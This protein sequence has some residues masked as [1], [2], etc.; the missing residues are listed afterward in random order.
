MKKRAFAEYNHKQMPGL[1]QL[2]KLNSDLLNLGDEV[3]IRAARSEKAVTIPIPRNIEDKDDSEDFK[4]GLPVLS[5]EDQAQADAAAAELEKS[6]NDFS[7]FL[8]DDKDEDSVK[9][10]KPKVDQTPDMSDIIGPAAGMDFDDFDLSE[11]EEAPPPKEP[12]KPKEIP[13]EDLDL[14]ALLAPSSKAKEEEVLQAAPVE[15]KVTEEVPFDAFENKAENKKDEKEEEAD[16]LL[17]SILGPQDNFIPEEK[18][19][20]DEF[21]ELANLNLEESPQSESSAQDDFVLPDLENF[22]FDENLLKN[23][24]LPSL[25]E[26]PVLEESPLLSESPLEEKENTPLTEEDKSDDPFSDFDADFTGAENLSDSINMNEGLPGEYDE[27]PGTEAE[28]AS[29]LSRPLKEESEEKEEESENLPNEDFSTPADFEKDLSSE[30]FSLPDFENEKLTEPSLPDFD[31]SG[32]DDMD[33]SQIPSGF[34]E[35]ALSSLPSESELNS[36]NESFS[37][38]SEKADENN[39]SSFT[40]NKLS[41]DSTTPPDIGD[42]FSS[43]SGD[44]FTVTNYE[45]GFDGRALPPSETDAVPEEDSGPAEIFDTSAMDGLDFSNEENTGLPSDFEL[46]NITTTESDDDI[47]NIPGFSDTVTADLNKKPKEV[48]H[49]PVVEDDSGKPKNSFTDAEYERFQKNLTF[50]PLNVRIALEDLVVKNEFTDD[51]VFEILEKVLR[52]VPARTLASELE[53]MMDI[54]LDV[55]RDFEHRTAEEYEAYKKSLEYQLKNRIIP[56]AIISTAAAIFIF[57]I[58]LLSNTFI[59]RPI[60]AWTLYKQGL[61]LIE[62]EEYPLSEDKFNQALVYNPEKDW[63]FTYAK[64]YRKHKQYDRARMMYNAILKRYNHDKKAGIQLAKMELEDLYNYEEAERILKKDVLVHNINDKEAVLLLGDTYLEWATEKDPSQY[65]KALEQYT[66]YEYFHGASDDCEKR[67]MRYFIRTDDLHTVLEYK[68]YFSNEAHSKSL[69]S[70]ELTELSGYLLDKRYGKLKPAE[71]A[72]RGYIDGLRG[73]LE[74]AVNADENNPVALYNY[75][76]YFVETKNEKA[77]AGILTYAEE[78]FEKQTR[79]NKKDTYKFI[80]TCRL[81]GEQYTLQRDFQ[82]AEEKYTKGIELFEKEKRSSNFESNEK[83]GNLYAD[84]ADLNYFIAQDYE[85]ALSNYVMAVDNKYD[86]SEVRY[87]IGYINYSNQKYS[88]ALGSFIKSHETS[89]DDTH[90]LLALAN[91]LSQNSDYYVAKGYYE[92]LIRLLNKQRTKWGELFPQTRDDQNDVADTY[93]KATNNLGVILSRTASQTGDSE[94]NGQAIVNFQESLRAWDALTRNQKT[95]I[96]MEGSNLAEQNIKYLTNNY[97]AY[98]PE[99]Y[100]EIPRTLTTEVE[101][102]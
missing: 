43:G 20:E 102:K 86:N 44:A 24:E 30:D 71:E 27:V 62:E 81:L 18:P 17:E 90:L 46:G 73:L 15:P 74:K 39:E 28:A 16:A 3:K 98:Q 78:A 61:A 29:I 31:T 91:T 87:K 85:T 40:P 97:T 14:D 36:I 94:L 26:S 66:R 9:E 99:I 65:P 52:K 60:K 42:M 25:E 58:F 38:P 10:E 77:A 84:Y 1:S 89:P 22:S 64:S 19:S 83:I 63:F 32:L 47:F 8:D 79:R 45:G 21:P 100:T 69:G 96:R 48:H 35:A 82:I 76:R 93:M 50:Y 13:I 49:A 72:L 59:Y 70:K 57:C 7:D 88:E 56:G 23:E 101:I 51:A 54:H 55:P 41:E 92:K 75:G 67:K 2:Q 80:D 5:E 53:K 12:E 37:D 34:D 33:F 95:M 6:A 68:E 4:F 11:F